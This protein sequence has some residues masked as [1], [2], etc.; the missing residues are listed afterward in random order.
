MKILV[1]CEFSGIVREAFRARGHKAISCDLVDSELP[2]PHI[3]CDVRELLHARFG[4][5]MLIAF[6]PCQFLA[7]SGLHWMYKIP[8]RYEAAT[9]ALD[10]VATLLAAP[11]PKISVENPKGLIGTNICKPDQVI[12]PNWFGH[13]E[14]KATCLW[15]KNLP[16]L[17]PTN[18][19][20]LKPGDAW[21]N[22]YAGGQHRRPGTRTRARDASRTYPGVAVAMA[23]QWG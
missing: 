16:K 14:S 8:G 9:D 13:R 17:R 11:I 6:P 7:R 1:A 10:F 2:G 15:L 5:D 22:T 19:I 3:Q 23:Q 20:F 4:W 21:N 18:R 12:Q